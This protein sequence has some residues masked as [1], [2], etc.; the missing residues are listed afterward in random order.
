MIFLQPLLFGLLLC[1]LTLELPSKLD[2]LL[3]FAE[4]FCRF[5]LVLKLLC[6]LFL[7]FLHFSLLLLLSRLC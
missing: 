2:L 5:L 4:L 6:I 1:D 7:D 3:C